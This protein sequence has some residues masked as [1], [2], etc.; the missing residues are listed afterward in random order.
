MTNPAIELQTLR[1]ENIGHTQRQKQEKQTKHKQKAPVQ[2]TTFIVSSPKDKMF[3]EYTSVDC[4][5]MVANKKTP[6][7]PKLSQ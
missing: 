5:W 1:K 4:R 7:N 6:R 3:P 2:I